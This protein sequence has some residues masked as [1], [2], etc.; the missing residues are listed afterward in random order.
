MDIE[1]GGASVQALKLPDEMAYAKPELANPLRGNLRVPP[2][3]LNSFPQPRTQGLLNDRRER[4]P[5]K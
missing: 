3:P 1:C 5:Q 2:K 4:T